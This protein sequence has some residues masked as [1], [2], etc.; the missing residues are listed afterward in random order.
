MLTASPLNPLFYLT[1]LQRNSAS[2]DRVRL[3]LR[4]DSDQRAFCLNNRYQTQVF[5]KPP[6]AVLALNSS[7]TVFLGA[8]EINTTAVV[9]LL[10][11]LNQL[12][13]RWL[14]WLNHGEN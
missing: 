8:G 1:D 6:F 7:P 11:R 5:A 4:A 2:V 13:L 9:S 10:L 14:R 3:G 12:R